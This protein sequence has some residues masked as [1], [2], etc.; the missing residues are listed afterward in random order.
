MR[1]GLLLTAA[2]AAVLAFQ[3]S[4]AAPGWE[5]ERT[6]RRTLMDL[7]NRRREIHR[8]EILRLRGSD[9]AVE[10]LT[11]GERLV[12]RPGLRRA[13]RADPLAGTFS[14]LSLEEI[15]AHRKRILEELRGAQARVA[16]T[17]SEKELAGLLEALD[18]QGEGPA[19]EVRSEGPR[20]ELRAGDRLILSA[21]VEARIPAVGWIEA[22]SS[23]GAFPASVAQAL[24]G[25]GGL[26]SR[27][28]FRY[29][30]FPDRVHDRFETLRA[31]PREI[32]EGA[33]ARPAGLRR[34]P[35]PGLEP[36]PERRP[37]PPAEFRNDFRE[38][39]LDGKTLPLREKL[40]K[41]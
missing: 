15:A 35:W 36:L 29:V 12:V 28:S 16:G 20:R 33:F 22:L 23:L 1:T 2:T 3:E 21:E 4:P 11:F 18:P 10:D 5:I 9:L 6:V 24:R 7:L 31:Q 32:P 26:P 39:D 19:V 40:R 34:V 14:E 27:G 17:A 30:L 13:W 41:P 37:L 8:R 25:L 38:D